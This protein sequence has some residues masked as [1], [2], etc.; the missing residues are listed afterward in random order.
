[1]GSQPASDER[2]QAAAARLARSL[3]Q[4]GQQI[5]LAESCTAGLV[6][7]SLGQIAG[8]SR[9]LCGSWVSYQEASK[10]QWLAI[11][12]ELL[13]QHTAVSSAVAIAMAQGALMRTDSADLAVSVTGHL[14][15]QAPADQDGQVFIAIACRQP[16][17]ALDPPPV[18]S[19]RLAA[20]PR[21][22]RQRLAAIAVLDAASDWLTDQP[23]SHGQPPTYSPPPAPPSSSPAPASGSL[24]TRRESEVLR[25]LTFGLTN[26]EIAK[27]LGISHETVKGH[28]QRIFRKVGVSDRTAAA[29]WAVRQN[30]V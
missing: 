7:A 14:G 8:I 12:A 15:P 5:V 2:L 18:L 16:D 3:Q 10:R 27:R 9:W 26:K 4:S 25:Q 22:Q 21:P 19:L 20:Q 17:P 30:L 29:V 24:L 23:A 6:A 13:Y 11:P 1:M 28:L